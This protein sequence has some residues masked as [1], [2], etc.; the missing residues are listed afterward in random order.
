VYT[1]LYIF[2]LLVPIACFDG[3]IVASCEHDTR[4]WMYGE[5]SDIVGMCLKHSNLVMCI[6]IE[7]AQLKV[8]RPGY[9]PVVVC[10][11]ANTSDRN[12]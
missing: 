3:N 12:G 4:S 5:T 6:V 9:K 10:D 1:Y 2:P 8:V 7:D 11:K